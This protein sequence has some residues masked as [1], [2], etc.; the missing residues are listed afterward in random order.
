MHGWWWT[1]VFLSISTMRSIRQHYMFI[2]VDGLPEYMWFSYPFT[3]SHMNPENLAQLLAI[4]SNSFA[5]FWVAYQEE[6]FIANIIIEDI[7]TAD[8]K[9][10]ACIAGIGKTRLFWKTERPRS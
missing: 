10:D 2:L 1:F 4:V 9:G 7:P 3:F 6:D 5:C 8:Y